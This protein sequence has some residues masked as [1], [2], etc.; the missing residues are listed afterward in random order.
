MLKK[1]LKTYIEDCSICK[2]GN[3]DFTCLK[4]ASTKLQRQ[5]PFIRDSVYPWKNYDWDYGNFIDNN[6]SAKA[7]GSSPSGRAYLKNIWIFLKF[8]DA[9]ITAANPNNRSRAGGKN[10]NSDYPIY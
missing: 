1:G 5:L 9:Y 10:K 3:N 4:E 7:T 2:R 8:L 6:F